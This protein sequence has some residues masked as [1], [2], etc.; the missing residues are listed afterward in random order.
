VF[1]GRRSA[2][3]V[4]PKSESSSSAEGSSS[5]AA[6]KKTDEEDDGPSFKDRQFRLSDEMSKQPA[7][8]KKPAATGSGG[9]GGGGGKGGGGPQLPNGWTTNQLVLVILG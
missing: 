3:K 2:G 6:E 1:G 5:S 4:Q 7:G 9:G 8:N